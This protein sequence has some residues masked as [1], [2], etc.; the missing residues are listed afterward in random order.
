MVDLLHYVV[1]TLA[2]IS[3]STFTKETEMFEVSF[4]CPGKLL[5]IELPYPNIY[6]IS[7]VILCTNTL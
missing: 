4:I 3:Y 7:L 2:S 1:R 5:V 6:D